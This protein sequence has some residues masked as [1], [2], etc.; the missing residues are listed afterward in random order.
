MPRR[1][2]IVLCTV[3]AA[4]AGCGSGSTSATTN[5]LVH[6]PPSHAVFVHALILEC[7]QGNAAIAA[8]HGN[9]SKVASIINSYVPKFRAL[10]T[11][12]TA[13]I[14]YRKFLA[15]IEAELAALRTGNS[16]ALKAA[17]AAGSKY[18]QELGAS[19]CAGK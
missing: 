7:Q 6:R 9:P 16:P 14:T 13:E 15:T 1:S 2:A 8:A 12:G 3:A 19:A 18:A 4:L 10:S 11:T 5:G 17:Q